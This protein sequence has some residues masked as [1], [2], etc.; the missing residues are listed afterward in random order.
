MFKRS[1][2]LLLI[3][4]I[5]TIFS[6]C[7][8]NNN[9]NSNNNGEPEHITG[10]PESYFI[11]GHMEKCSNG[12]KYIT[13]ES[14]EVSSAYENDTI[15]LNDAGCYIVMSVSS[16]LTSD[17]FSNQANLIELWLSPQERLLLN[18]VLW[19][20]DNGRL[21]YEVPKNESKDYSKILNLKISTSENSN[22]YYPFLNIIY[23]V[24]K[25][26]CVVEGTQYCGKYIMLKLE[27]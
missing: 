2:I 5:I 20:V 17:D 26:Y 7:I 6:G 15:I 3:L 13:V 8:F 4:V 18:F 19:D 16:N 27:Y 22:D 14:F 25:E 24:F 12:D 21:V 23:D 11:Y 1:L 9:P 10:Y